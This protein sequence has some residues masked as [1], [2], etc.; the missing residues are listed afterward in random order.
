M[1]GCGGWGGEERY[2]LSDGDGVPKLLQRD[3]FRHGDDEF[4]RRGGAGDDGF[5]A[6]RGCMAAETGRSLRGK[7]AAE[8]EA[9]DAAVRCGGGC[10][11]VGHGEIVARRCAGAGFAVR[12]ASRRG[13]AADAGGVL[14]KMGVNRTEYEPGMRGVSS[15]PI[16]SKRRH[17]RSRRQRRRYRSSKRSPWECRKE[18]A[19][20]TWAYSKFLFPQVS[21]RFFV[22]GTM[23][24]LV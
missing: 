8:G 1:G 18:G 9:R 16:C 20:W 23:L 19:T 15:L 24:S 4:R 6:D 5:L 21:F 22:F 13:T 10:S 3:C 17:S 12:T 7:A 14:M 11:A 2:G